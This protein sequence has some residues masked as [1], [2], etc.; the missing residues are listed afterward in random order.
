[1]LPSVADGKLIRIAQAIGEEA[2]PIKHSS[3]V[4]VVDTNAFAMERSI[5][6]V[7]A[8]AWTID[9]ASGQ[10]TRRGAAH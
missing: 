6:R 3:R 2:T 9:L 8:N 10:K 5:G 7:Y 4:L 1:M